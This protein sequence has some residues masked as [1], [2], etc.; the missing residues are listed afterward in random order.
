[1]NVWDATVMP[2]QTMHP[3]IFIWLVYGMWLAVLVYLTIAA[4][5]VKRDTSGSVGQRLGIMFGMIAAV[6]LPFLPV[7]RFLNF[8]PGLIV[9][10]IGLTICITGWVFFVWARQNLGSNWSGNV[11]IQ[12]GQE[13]ITSGPYRYL[14]HP[15]YSGGLVAC[16][17]SAIVVGG[18]FIFLLIL[19][20]PVF[21]WRSSAEDTLM[22]QQ[23]PSEYPAYKKRTNALIPFVW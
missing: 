20:T 2:H 3:S 19:L 16:I 15:M 8:T 14:R 12:E 1:M 17:G 18:L 7:F 6:G 23:F 11:S 5:G 21:V 13:L 10:S 9:G 22:E 4:K